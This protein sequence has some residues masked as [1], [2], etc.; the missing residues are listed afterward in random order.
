LWAGIKSAGRSRQSTEDRNQ[1]KKRLAHTGGFAEN[2]ETKVRSRRVV[3]QP[4]APE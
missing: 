1:K 2:W 4:R 3:A